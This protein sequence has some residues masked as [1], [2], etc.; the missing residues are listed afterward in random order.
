MSA[1]INGQQYQKY[2]S[3]IKSAIVNI[4]GQPNYPIEVH[5]SEKTV[6]SYMQQGQE[7]IEDLI[8]QQIKQDMLFFIT[9]GNEALQLC[10]NIRPKYPRVYCVEVYADMDRNLEEY[11]KSR[12]K[13]LELGNYDQ[14]LV[15]AT[16]VAESSLTI[17]GLTYVIDSGYELH[18]RFD[19]NCYG[20]ILEKQLIS[21][22]Q[23]LQRR[24]RVGRTAPGICYHLMTQEQFGELKDY[25]STRYFKTRYY[26]GSN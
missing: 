18:S 15:M 26:N 11:A 1:T 20:Q 23:A 14:K 10:R 2:F 5:F 21:K 6:N 9:T 8:H 16:N 17:D 24:G 12:D 4:S 7:L 13:Y 22:A 25:P 19:P 3:G